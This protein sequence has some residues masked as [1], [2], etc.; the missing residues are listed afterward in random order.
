[1]PSE[2]IVEVCAEG[3]T[4]TLFGERSAAGHWRFWTETD[5]MTLKESFEDEDLGSL[6]VLV[7]TSESVTSLPEALALLDKYPWFRLIPFQ[8][9]PEFQVAILREVQV[10]ATP[11]EVASWKER[12]KRSMR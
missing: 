12:L 6:G 7:N 4:L 5:E 9:H 8:V 10:R 11:E 2:V 1:M 3:G